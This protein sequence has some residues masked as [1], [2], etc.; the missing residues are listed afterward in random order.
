MHA[1]TR[2][3]K[4]LISLFFL[5]LSLFGVERFE[6]VSYAFNKDLRGWE[7]LVKDNVSKQV[8][9]YIINDENLFE[10]SG[11]LNVWDFVIWNIPNFFEVKR[12]HTHW[13]EPRTSK[14]EWDD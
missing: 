1:K 12:P 14:P 9:G 4:I 7:V 13:H 8:Y 10:E 11:E 6:F 3:H 5:P 2:W